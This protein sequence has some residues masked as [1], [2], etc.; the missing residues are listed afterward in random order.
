[1][2]G[3][4]P[5]DIPA[6]PDLARHFTGDQPLEELFANVDEGLFNLRFLKLKKGRA[7]Q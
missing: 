3:F 5:P 7:G 4:S 6:P 1:M 2:A